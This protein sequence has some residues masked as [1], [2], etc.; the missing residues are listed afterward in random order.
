MERKHKG[1]RIVS[2]VLLYNMLFSAVSV[3]LNGWSFSAYVKLFSYQTLSVVIPGM[4]MVLILRIKIASDVGW[5]GYSFVMGYV[6]NI[7]LYYVTVP[8]GLQIY[9]KVIGV[10]AAALSMVLLWLKRSDVIGCEHDGAGMKI[11]TVGV[12]V[13]AVFMFIAYNGNGLSPAL[14]GRTDYYTYHRDIQYWIGNLHS[15]IKQYPPLNP[16]D[17][18]AG[19]FNYHYFSSIQLAVQAIWTGI[20][21]AMLCMGAY[22]HVTVVM[23]VFGAYLFAKSVIPEQRPVVLAMGAL[24]L[25]SGIENVTIVE[26]ICHY[27]LAAFGTDY[28]LGVMLFF[29]LALYQYSMG[30]QSAVNGGGGGTI[31]ILLLAVLTGS[32]GPYGAVALCGIGV[33]CLYWLCNRKPLR[34]VVFGITA[35]S[36][37]GIIYFF[38]CNTAGYV[39]D[40]NSASI[41]HLVIRTDPSMSIPEACFRKLVRE[42]VNILLMKPV[43]LW[44]LA[45]IVFTKLCRR[46][47]FS[48]FEWSCLGMA[49]VGLSVNALIRIPGNSQGYFALAA[50]VPAWCCVL[51]NVKYDKDIFARWGSWKYI[52]AAVMLLIGVG[53][54]LWGYNRNGNRFGVFYSI[55][56]GIYNIAHRMTGQEMPVRS[57]GKIEDGKMLG[58]QEYEQ[59]TS[60]YGD[61]EL[62]G[63]LLY[64][65]PE[66]R[67]D[68]APFRKNLISSFS[69]KYIWQNTEA[70]NA[71][72]EED[73]EQMQEFY[74]MGVRYLLVDFAAESDISIPETNA[75]MIYDSS[76][77]RIYK[78][79][80]G[81]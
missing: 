7:L 52:V 27:A 6:Y 8:F 49:F 54:F 40:G 1:Y 60:L 73:T 56:D 11:C 51:C 32:K 50:L 70:V 28:G 34:A 47:R 58:K 74:D 57:D 19:I 46:Q 81:S 66:Q 48:V 30:T 29:I 43:V 25:T 39:G 80:N 9:V 42:A 76:E 37:F 23:V 38:V 44:P 16:R 17:Y 15:L 62:D 53:G 68:L 26:H 13:Y 71:F 55:S 65:L 59:L 5:I 21:P 64:S 10:A 45:V 24:L 69:G 18:D 2:W 12:I 61:G 79:Y 63:I 75:D 33:V 35:L 22:F 67:A 36:V 78:I 31:C 72:I 77:M 20:H 4:A 3:L 14:L 41:Y